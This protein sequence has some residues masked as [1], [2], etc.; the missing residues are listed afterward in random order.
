VCR[1]AKGPALCRATA[2]PN[3]AASRAGRHSA[4]RPWWLRRR[5]RRLRPWRHRPHR[6]PPPRGQHHRCPPRPRPWHRRARQRRRRVAMRP[7]VI[8][9]ATTSA[10]AAS[11]V[12]SR[13]RTCASADS[14]ADP[15][16]P[17]S[18]LGPAQPAA[19]GLAS[20]RPS[21]RR[22]GGSAWSQG[23]CP[24]TPR[25]RASAPATHCPACADA[26]RPW[27]GCG[28]AGTAARPAGHR[29]RPPAGRAPGPRLP[30]WPRR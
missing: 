26:P 3:C 4:R 12:R 24:L 5:A 10:L 11:A 1:A 2:A 28:P 22:R 16:A 25:A 14:L 30:P 20:S 18:S 15:A 27:G 29:P 6:C 23:R 7:R 17:A 21:T 8:G 9:S 13:G 19:G